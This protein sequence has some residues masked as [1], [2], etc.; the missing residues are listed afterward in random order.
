MPRVVAKIES[1]G[2]KAGLSGDVHKILLKAARK[3]MMF[4]EIAKSAGC[5]PQALR[6]Q[7]QKVGIN[8]FKPRFDDKVKE[9]GYADVRDF[10]TDKKNVYKTMKELSDMT[11]FCCHTVSRYYHKFVEEVKAAQEKE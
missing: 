2:R 11:G 7:L 3:N 10:F 5:T 9:L 1:W 6:Y 8:S 4:S